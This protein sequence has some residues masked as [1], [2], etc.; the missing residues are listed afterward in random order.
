MARV[1]VI[2]RKVVEED[3]AHAWTLLQQAL[4]VLCAT[5]LAD[6]LS[7]AQWF[8]RRGLRTLVPGSPEPTATEDECWQAWHLRLEARQR[9]LSRIDAHAQPLCPLHVGDHVR[10]Q[11]KHTGEWRDRGIVVNLRPGGRSAVVEVGNRKLLRNRK[12]LATLPCEAQEQEGVD[13]DCAPTAAEE[14][15]QPPTLQPGPVTR[16]R[17]RSGPAPERTGR[18]NSSAPPP[19]RE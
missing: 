5:P 19:S 13:N 3:H 2:L 9:Q 6:E 17:G 16:S 11:D 7:R 8:Y 1:K 10:I 15:S 14:A 4:L 18:E 12:F